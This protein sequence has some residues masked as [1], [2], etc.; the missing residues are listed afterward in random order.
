MIKRDG[1]ADIGVVF[2]QIQIAFLGCF[3]QET[4]CPFNHYV[5]S[6]LS[7]QPAK[8]FPFMR[9]F[10]KTK[11]VGDADV[12]YTG[13]RHGLCMIVA[14]NLIDKTFEGNDELVFAIQKDILL[15]MRFFV[16]DKRPEN[17]GGD[18]AQIATY[19]FVFVVVVAFFVFLAMPK[20]Q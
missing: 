15:G 8:G 4:L 14:G 11:Q 16:Y 2:Y 3:K 5:K 19:R 17:A 7:Q 20:R 9:L 10:V 18:K 13:I 12:N 1:I 6:F